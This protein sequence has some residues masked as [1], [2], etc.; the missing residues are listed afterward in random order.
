[1]LALAVVLTVVVVCGVAHWVVCWYVDS[2]M[3]SVSLQTVWTHV[4][5]ANKKVTQ[6]FSNDS[7][8]LL[9]LQTVTPPPGAEVNQWSYT[10]T[11][12][13]SSTSSTTSSNGNAL[14]MLNSMLTPHDN[15]DLSTSQTSTSRSHTRTDSSVSLYLFAASRALKQS[16]LREAKLRQ[17]LDRL[18]RLS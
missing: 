8:G 15:K 4:P 5:S 11:K 18:S 3:A 7:D 12:E 6:R 2:R 13:N 14:P 1:M 16:E 10:I 17:Q 9:E